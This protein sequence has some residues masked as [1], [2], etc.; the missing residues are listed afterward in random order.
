MENL[1]KKT[2]RERTLAGFNYLFLVQIM[3]F[4]PDYRKKKRESKKEYLC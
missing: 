1:G 3:C 2:G 4:L